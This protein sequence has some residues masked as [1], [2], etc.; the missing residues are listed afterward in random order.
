MK[1]GFLDLV[2]IKT[3]N[4]WSLILLGAY[5][6]SNLSVGRIRMSEIDQNQAIN[7]RDHNVVRFYISMSHLIHNLQV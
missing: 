7:V 4:F 6:F 3:I 5:S 2:I 1:V